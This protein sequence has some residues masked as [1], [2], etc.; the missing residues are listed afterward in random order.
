MT[1]GNTGVEIA[2]GIF[3]LFFSHILFGAMLWLL[4]AISPY[5]GTEFFVVLYAAIAISLTQLIYAI[6]LIIYFRRRR[7][8][9]AAKGVVVGI[10]IT[11]LLNGGCFLLIGPQLKNL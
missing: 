9:N 7:R 4:V 11:A 6:P 10:V 3:I 2:K 5:R 8:F 1:Q